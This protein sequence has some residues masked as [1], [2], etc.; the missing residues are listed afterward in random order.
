VLEFLSRIIVS[1][2]VEKAL[3]KLFSEPNYSN[4]DK[5]LF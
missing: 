4:F 5:N 3:E 2:V 1:P